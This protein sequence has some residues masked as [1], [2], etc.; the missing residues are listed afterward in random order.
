MGSASSAEAY[1][2]ANAPAGWQASALIR[3]INFAHLLSYS[4]RRSNRCSAEF[5][6]ALE[7]PDQTIIVQ[8][9]ASAK[10]WN[11]GRWVSGVGYSGQPSLEP[12]AGFRGGA[13]NRL[14]L[15]IRVLILFTCSVII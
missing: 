15:L 1:R 10:R 2:S 12:F 5:A 4:V 9:K 7:L 11:P 3:V 14:Y 8:V 13:A 6:T